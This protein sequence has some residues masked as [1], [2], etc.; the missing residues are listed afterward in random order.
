MTNG[1]T[2]EKVEL[3]HNSHPGALTIGKVLLSNAKPLTVI[4][5][6][7][8]LEATYSITT[9]HRMLSDLTPLIDGK[10][11]ILI[12]GDF[13]ASPQWDTKQQS[14]R[15][16]FN[17]L[18]DFGFTNCLADK[19]FVKT[20]RSPHPTTKNFPWQLDYLFASNDICARL[21]DCQ[22]LGDDPKIHTFS[23]HNPVVA[24]FD[25]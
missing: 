16:L 17:R 22:V 5:L 21:S 18:E 6:Y 2:V 20:W 7:G 12:G 15:I 25:L 19:G 1:L 4:S 24:V 9:L 14:H 11:R 3:K 13:N 8:L 10:K 23:D